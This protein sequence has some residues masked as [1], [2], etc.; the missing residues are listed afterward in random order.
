MKQANDICS[1][2]DDHEFPALSPAYLLGSPLLNPSSWRDFEA[3]SR[4]HELEPVTSCKSSPCA[5]LIPPVTSSSHPS[6][7][8]HSSEVLRFK[9]CKPHWTTITLSFFVA[10][11]I[12]KHR[13][14]DHLF[15]LNVDALF[16][17]IGLETTQRWLFE[18]PLW[19]SRRFRMMYVAIFFSGW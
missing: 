4:L 10:L 3:C 18:D 5:M 15:Y 12:Q 11:R 14:K 6:S 13:W 8:D 17:R 16:A 7:H 1:V 19:P 2:V 9:L